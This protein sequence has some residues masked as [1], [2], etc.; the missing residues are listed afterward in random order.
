MLSSVT[1]NERQPD[2][3]VARDIQGFAVG[4]PSTRGFLRA[5]KAHRDRM[6]T[7]VYTG[8]DLAGNQGSCTVTVSVPCHRERDGDDKLS[9]WLRHLFS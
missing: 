4:T 3:D 1:S 6:Y 7:F 5:E 9:E 8:T 2:K